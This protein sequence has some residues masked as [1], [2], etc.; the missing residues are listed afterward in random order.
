MSL[1]R[2]EHINRLIGR[3]YHLGAQGPDSFDCYSL[4]RTLQAGLFGREM[5][6]FAAPAQAG[7][8]AIAAAVAIHP[9]RG[10]WQE[11]PHPQDGAIVTMARHLQGYHLGTFIAEDGG[12][13]VHALEGTGVVASRLCELEA[14]GWRKFRFHI[15]L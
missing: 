3:P 6:A 8:M 14:E 4:T 10:R 12:L 7:R 5:P 13:V 9:E 15:P 1:G 2:A 11:M